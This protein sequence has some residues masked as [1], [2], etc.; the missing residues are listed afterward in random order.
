MTS[1]SGEGDTKDS[2]DEALLL[3]D[4]LIG[5][6]LPNISVQNSAEQRLRANLVGVTTVGNGGDGIHIGGPK[7]VS[8]VDVDVEM[9]YKAIEALAE[10]AMLIQEG[11]DKNSNRIINELG[12]I[13]GL[14][15]I[16][17][18]LGAIASSVGIPLSHLPFP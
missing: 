10:V 5:E 7:A 1:N 16:P 2:I 9:C 13:N 12:E 18:K 8:N 6:L 14:L 4:Q 17:V 15:G 3:I 11:P